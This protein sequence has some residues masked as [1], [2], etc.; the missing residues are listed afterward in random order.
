MNR[1]RICSR[2]SFLIFLS[3]FHSFFLL[4]ETMYEHFLKECFFSQMHFS[5]FRLIEWLWLWFLLLDF[6]LNWLFW[7]NDSFLIDC[8]WVTF[9][10][11]AALTIAMIRDD[12]EFFLIT[13]NLYAR[14]ILKKSTDFSAVFSWFSQLSQKVDAHLRSARRNSLTKMTSSS[15]VSAN[16][17]LIICSLRFSHSVIYDS[18]LFLTDE[19]FNFRHCLWI[20]WIILLWS[21]L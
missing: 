18:T 2:I 1:F 10:R 13:T 17:K 14:V 9:C 21:N 11:V 15:K 6:W 4:N 7:L 16:F 20:C 12:D 19:V 5:S 8:F 3:F